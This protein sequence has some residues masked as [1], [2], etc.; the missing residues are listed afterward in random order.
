MST[1]LAKRADNGKPVNIV[2]DVSLATEGHLA[3]TVDGA[4]Y[5]IDSNHGQALE[6]V[7]S[8]NLIEL[9]A[10]SKSR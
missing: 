10:R 7:I 5:L 3:L 1:I 6:L 8:A 4:D 2:V 9:D